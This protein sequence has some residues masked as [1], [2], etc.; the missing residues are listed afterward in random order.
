MYKSIGLLGR[1]GKNRWRDSFFLLLPLG[2]Q[3]LNIKYKE[4]EET[5]LIFKK[6]ILWSEKMA[7]NSTHKSKRSLE[8]L[9]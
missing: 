8:I 3:E 2:N 4:S 9:Y 1:R 6:K 7:P 5:K